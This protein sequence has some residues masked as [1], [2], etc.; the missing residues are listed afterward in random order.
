MLGNSEILVI[1]IF[2]LLLFGPKKLPELAHS[3][4]KAVAEYRRAARELEEEA[5]RE[6][7]EVER[8]I[9]EARKEM[10]LL[11]D[12]ARDMNI[13]PTGKSKEE[14]LKEIKKRTS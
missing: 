9:E 8:E 5:R 7:S 1:L 3:L 12:I 10:D 6:L 13:D 4:G 11:R 2:A 14:L